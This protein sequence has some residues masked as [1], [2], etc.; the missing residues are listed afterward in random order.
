MIR[1]ILF[2]LFAC[3]IC[4]GAFAQN[5]LKGTVVDA[6]T[7]EP[8]QG[9]TV[10]LSNITGVITDDHGRFEIDCKRFSNITITY[11]GYKPYS[12]SIKNCNEKLTI[13]L[14]PLAG[15]NNDVEITAITSQKKSILYQPVSISKLGPVE[16]NRGT[17]LYLK[18]AINTNVP[19]V[20]MQSRGISSGQ[21]INIRGYGAG[22]SGTR[23]VSSNFDG[24]GYKVYLNGIPITTAEGITIM[25]DI[26]FN[27]IGNV[28]LV[29]G[30][31]GSL[32][33][34][35]V[36]GV[37]N[38]ETKKPEAGKTSISQE[39][40]FGS[41][42][43]RR[44]TTTFSTATDNASWLVNYGSQLN[45]GYMLHTKSNKKF[46][47]VFGNFKA[48]PKDFV[49]TYFGY[50]NSYDERGGEDS[51]A[52]FATNPYGGNIQYVMR[53]GHSKIISFRA[54]V[55]NTY[56]FSN[57]ISNT[58]TVFGTSE[59]GDNSSAVG[60][61]D[62]NSLNYG[63]RSTFATNFRIADKIHLS[64][65]TGVETQQQ[66]A[67]SIGYNMKQSPLDTNTH[68]V[69]PWM[70][71]DPYYVINANTSNIITRTSTTTVFTEWTLSLPQDFSVTA[72]LGASNM[73]IQLNNRFT[74]ATATLPTRFDTSYAFRLSPH[75]AINKVFNKQFSMYAS[76][77][78][79]YKMPVSSYFYIP[80]P[81]DATAKPATTASA[82][83]NNK[84]KPEIGNQFEIGTKGATTDGRLNY[85]LA[86]FDAIFSDKMT[87][88]GIPNAAG[89]G[90]LY[91]MV[92]NGG[93]QDD[94]GIEAS[95]KY[96]IVKSNSGLFQL[97]QPFVNYAYSDFKYKNFKYQTSLT[98]F[99]DCSG[100]AVPGVSKNVVNTG[101]DLWL[102][103]GFY[104]NAVYS[105]RDG[106]T[107][108]SNG[109]ITLGGVPNVPYHAGSYSL[110]NTKVGYQHSLCYHFDLN[111]Y[112]GID[113]VT[114]TK[115]PAMVFLNQIPDAFIPAPK[116]GIV[117][118]G[119]NL[120]YNF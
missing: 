90:I 85:E 36:A 87:I 115:Y 53:N 66:R 112:L 56:N 13:A 54:G 45:N 89:T 116:H 63:L 100:D 80:I 109:L 103:C 18:D 33:G 17:G 81:A 108:T 20:L 111:V 6:Q 74:P 47:N 101:I 102:K 24:Q 60:W 97:V 73:G 93:K 120:K 51:V 86:L 57:H 64:G 22:T 50:S 96:A 76:Y 4:I 46:I 106:M 59:T 3:A 98:T 94:K 114:N 68:N 7:N 67:T 79:A 28:E 41:Y 99:V 44:Y 39:T 72:G 110:L 62:V 77:S 119:I 49:S 40:M 14:T 37:V 34:L 15:E 38:L 10:S 27:S 88:S 92:T 35:A 8:L 43:L 70:W 42:G 58:T 75:I 5:I 82:I 31:A 113:N 16:L 32:Y 2:F 29:K 105:Y 11:I 83:L 1:K 118:G 104:A 23:Q 95:L 65:L 9:A 52:E 69:R 30:P 12:Y 19:G 61:T 25:D 84:L 107:L 117:Y 48:N 26:D 91:S 78:K 21:Q 55:S 71:G